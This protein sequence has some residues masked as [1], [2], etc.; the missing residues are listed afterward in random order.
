ME[1]IP[2]NRITTK[3]STEASID[4]LMRIVGES[5]HTVTRE[6]VETLWADYSDDSSQEWLALGEDAYTLEVL[7]DYSVA[8]LSFMEKDKAQHIAE[9]LEATKELVDHRINSWI[10]SSPDS[11]DKYVLCCY[12]DF[13]SKEYQDAMTDVM[14]AATSKQIKESVEEITH[15]LESHEIDFVSSP[16]DSGTG[17]TMKIDGEPA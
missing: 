2:K 7:V 16:R 12:M 9:I 8:P 15:F 6:N 3:H 13:I 11:E 4:E 1:L 17:V 5:E 10:S 14:F